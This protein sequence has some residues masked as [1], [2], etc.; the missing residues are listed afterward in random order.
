M[1]RIGIAGVGRL[2]RFHAGKFLADPRC[3][4]AGVY[5]IDA[6]RGREAARDFKVTAFNSQAE[7]LAAC[8]AVDIAA[9]TSAHYELAKAALLAGKP[10]FVEKPLCAELAAAEELVGLAEKLGLSIQVGHIERFNPVI[11]AAEKHISAPLFI[12][13][14][15][16]SSFQPRGTDVSVVLDLMIHDIDLILDFV[17][18]PL[19]AVRANGAGI[20][21]P[22]LDIANAR[23]EFA[24]GAVAN[25]TSSRV[26]LKQERQL[27]FFQ[28]N[29]YVSLDLIARQGSV[30]KRGED[31]ETLLQKMMRG[32]TRVKPEELIHAQRLDPGP[33]ARD[34]LALELESWVDAIL[35]SSKPL[36][37]G[38]AGLRAMR[39][40]ALITDAINQQ[41]KV[42]YG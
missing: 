33:E 36:V 35:N 13:S 23:L 32:D 29:A 41:P 2:G 34:A 8:D 17:N 4:L 7:L 27:R 11:L 18:S 12:E 26:A 21:T 30:I 6:T 39:A 28:K 15:R 19:T 14:T 16:I 5:D 25:V 20:L 40:A 42:N 9:T 10:V 31:S 1:L 38:E 3:A 24:C 37:D 22:S